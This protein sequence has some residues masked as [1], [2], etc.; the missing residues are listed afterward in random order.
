VGGDGEGPSRVRRAA[1]RSRPEK[2]SRAGTLREHSLTGKA[3]HQQRQGK[4]EHGKQ[5]QGVQV[6]RRECEERE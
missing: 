6:A 1:L 2:F 5:A 4:R 3:A